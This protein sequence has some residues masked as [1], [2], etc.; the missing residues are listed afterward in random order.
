[1]N[2]ETECAGRGGSGDIG[3]KLV[4]AKSEPIGTGQEEQCRQWDLRV[5]SSGGRVPGVFERQQ[6]G[7]MAGEQ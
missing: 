1:M 3:V 4:E 2:S 6:E 7:P 5:K